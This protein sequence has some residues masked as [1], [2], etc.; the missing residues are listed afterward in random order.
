GLTR[1]IVCTVNHMWSVA[2]MV[3]NS[4]LVGM[5][6]RNMAAP[7]AEQ[8]N[9][10]MFPPPINAPQHSW[11]LNWHSDFDREAGHMWLRNLIRSIASGA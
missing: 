9:L 7:I 3:A 11:H 10:K 2:T 5:V 6:G 8:F 4:D 1:A